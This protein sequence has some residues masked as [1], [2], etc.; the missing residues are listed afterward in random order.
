MT[1]WIIKF[2]RNTFNF[3]LSLENWRLKFHWKN[4]DFVM[5]EN[6]SNNFKKFSLL[7]SLFTVIIENKNKCFF[8]FESLTDYFLGLTNCESQYLDNRKKLRGIFSENKFR[9][10][11]WVSKC[12]SGWSIKLRSKYK[13]IQL[14]FCCWLVWHVF[15]LW[16]FDGSRDNV[17]NNHKAS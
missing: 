5:T 1:L 12:F 10:S 17:K 3:D 6:C 11:V 16:N 7:I 15:N 4:L 13:P 9:N 14:P 8:S 2:L